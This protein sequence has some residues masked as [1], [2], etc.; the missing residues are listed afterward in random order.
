MNLKKWVKE[1]IL[2]PF[3]VC[4]SA[5][6]TGKVAL[7]FDDGPFNPYTEQ[8]LDVLD[9]AGMKATFFV[10]GEQV[11]KYPEITKMIEA[12]GH[13]LGNHS[14]THPEFSLLGYHAISDELDDVW[15]LLRP[16]DQ[17][18]EPRSLFRPPKGVI[19]LGLLRYILAKKQKAIL[20]NVDPEDYKATSADEITAFFEQ[21]PLIAGDIALLHDKT[22]YTPMALKSLLDQL[23]ASGL[24]SVTVS[25]LL[26]G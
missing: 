17:A 6:G 7:T 5:T 26:K 4:R 25:E 21:H 14:M 16:D 15:K 9:E 11:K 10:V 2:S 19:T 22:P 1:V 13:E 3:L 23:A 18:S 8:V 20:W 12:R 24:Q